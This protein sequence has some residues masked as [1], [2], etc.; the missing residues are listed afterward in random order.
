MRNPVQKAQSCPNGHTLTSE[1]SCCVAHLN[2]PQAGP[3]PKRP[4]PQS[5]TFVIPDKWCCAHG[6]GKSASLM[7]ECEER[8]SRRRSEADCARQRKPPT[9]CH[10]E[11][12]EA[13]LFLG[14]FS[15]PK[16]QTPN[17]ILHKEHP[18]M[19]RVGRASMKPST[20]P[21]MS[22]V[23][24]G[25]KR[26]VSGWLFFPNFSVRSSCVGKRST[27][28]TYVFVQFMQR[29]PF[30]IDMS[31]HSGSRVAVL[32]RHPFHI[33]TSLKMCTSCAEGLVDKA[34][35]A[36]GRIKGSGL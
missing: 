12:H 29:N 31:S 22:E 14:G 8:V 17:C 23:P 7:P 30:L 32:G 27:C 16:C 19:R 3:G 21:V 24:S 10:Q 4:D 33:P 18:Q 9:A 26:A 11:V 13:G 15:P 34:G 35:H 1:L 25:V 2:M 36:R 20:L 5:Q 6:S 28:T